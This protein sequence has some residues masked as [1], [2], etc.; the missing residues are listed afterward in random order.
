MHLQFSTLTEKINQ[1]T[2]LWS[3]LDIY[4]KKDLVLF[5]SFGFVGFKQFVIDNDS[6]IIDK[7]LFSL[8][9]TNNHISLVSLNFSIKAYKKMKEKNSR[10]NLT[11]TAK[12]FFHMI[13]QFAKLKVKKKTQKLLFQKI[14]FKNLQQTHVEYFNIT[15][16]KTYLTH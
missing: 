8:K 1:E 11:D 6:T 2:H 13:F 10:E 16:I 15:S 9:K 7:M 12:D 14:N 5:D 3:F 4:P